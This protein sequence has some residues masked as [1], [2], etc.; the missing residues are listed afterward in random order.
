MEPKRV[1]F[2]LAAIAI[3]SGLLVTSAYANPE[4]PVV[5]AEVG[6]EELPEEP[7]PPPFFL[8]PE[9][10]AA[11]DNYRESRALLEAAKQE[12]RENWVRALLLRNP[13]VRAAQIATQKQTELDQFAR[14]AYMNGV[15]NTAEMILTTKATTIGEFIHSTHY[16]QYA[17]GEKAVET[18]ETIS[19][20]EAAQARYDVAYLQAQKSSEHTIA[21][22]ERMTSAG[23]STR[24][25]AASKGPEHV[26]AILGVTSQDESGCPTLSNSLT[27]DPSVTTDINT[28]CQQAMLQSPNEYARGAVRWAT[29]RVGSPYACQGVG[30]ENNYQFDCSSFVVRAYADGAGIDA[31]YNGWSPSTHTMLST[32]HPIFKVAEPKD[33]AVGDLVLYDTCPEGEVC[34]YNHVV[35]YLG[36]IQGQQLMVHTNRCG[37]VSH[38]TEF[39]GLEDGENGRFL[40]V[41]K[42]N[43][44]GTPV[45]VDEL[46]G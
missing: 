22:R 9:V 43:S 18:L 3:S 10:S 4:P 46:V 27:L 17:S 29:S 39:W 21:S 20:A 6:Q 23:Q 14:S 19:A 1:V 7:P 32:T 24:D 38:I 31:R 44:E 40:G 16:T 12:E 26:T 42:M 15:P 33:L 34:S 28:I 41:R 8:D 13:A 36:E 11:L 35:M 25:L 5:E 37:G 30:R 2:A 45:P